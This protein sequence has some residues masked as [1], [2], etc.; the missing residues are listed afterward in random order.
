MKNWM[1]DTRKA[2]AIALLTIGLSLPGLAQEPARDA[3]ADQPAPAVTETNE[4]DTKLVAEP[5]VKQPRPVELNLERVQDWPDYRAR[6]DIPALPNLQEDR[7][8][9]RVREF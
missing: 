6:P 8:D 3:A 2:L 1:N 5:T 9:M 4:A 7:D